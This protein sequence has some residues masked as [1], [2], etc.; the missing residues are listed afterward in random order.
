MGPRKNLSRLHRTQRSR[1]RRN[2]LL[3]SR[4]LDP[5]PHLFHISRFRLRR[6]LYGRF[7]HQ[8]QHQ[9]KVPLFLSP[10]HL[11]LS[12]GGLGVSLVSAGMSFSIATTVFA[13]STYSNITHCTQDHCWREYV[14]MFAWA[15]LVLPFPGT[16]LLLFYNK[17]EYP[18]LCQSHNSVQS[19]DEDEYAALLS[20]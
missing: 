1:L 18:H 10:S 13:I 2:E 8:H 11:F 9:S 20:K 12:N 15:C 4:N 6:R 16:L 3:H 17:K 5:R 14:R 19:N 7:R